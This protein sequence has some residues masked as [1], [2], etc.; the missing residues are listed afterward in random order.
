MLIR[1]VNGEKKI[2]ANNAT[3]V[4]TDKILSQSPTGVISSTIGLEYN[5]A[6]KE[7][8]LT[9]RTLGTG[10]DASNVIGKIN[11]DVESALTWA[12]LLTADNTGFDVEAAPENLQ[13]IIS[14]ALGVPTATE[15]EDET[16]TYLTIVYDN[17]GIYD[18]N[19]QTNA[20]YSVTFAEV[21]SLIDNIINEAGNNGIVIG[22]GND[23]NKIKLQLDSNNANLSIVDTAAEGKQIGL[24]FDIPVYTGQQKN[25]VY[26]YNENELEIPTLPPPV[27]P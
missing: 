12:G 26:F 14:N 22:T 9:G 6:S 23:K 3:V 18:S 20:G 5:S 17:Q 8:R 21:S 1:I 27:N 24:T 15:N 11:L 16:K 7:I 19:T 2:I 10:Q 13:S 25:G 4:T